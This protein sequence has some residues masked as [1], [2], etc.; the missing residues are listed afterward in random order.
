MGALNR[1]SI[2]LSAII[3]TLGICRFCLLLSIMRFNVVR[4]MFGTLVRVSSQRGL[5]GLTG[6]CMGLLVAIGIM[7]RFE[8]GLLPVDN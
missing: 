2:M 6:A 1:D 4:I 8:S 5:H 7:P 3:E